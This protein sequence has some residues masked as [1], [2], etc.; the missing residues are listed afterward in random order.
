MCLVPP[1]SETTEWGGG[2]LRNPWWHGRHDKVNSGKARV[3]NQIWRAPLPNTV[4]RNCMHLERD[5]HPYTK[6]GPD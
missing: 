1:K 3:R 6:E 2:W 4:F 5:A